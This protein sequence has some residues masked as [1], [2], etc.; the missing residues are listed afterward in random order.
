MTT[1]IK[2]KGRNTFQPNLISWSYRYLGTMALTKANKKNKSR[3]FSINHIAP[4]INVNG[5][6]SK[7][8]N[9]PPK[10]KIAPIA[11]INKMFAYSPSQNI[12]YIIP[13]YSV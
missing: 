9:Q 11:H 5:K 10:N 2:E 3:I 13:E 4:G 7:G 8:D 6:I 1:H 12:A